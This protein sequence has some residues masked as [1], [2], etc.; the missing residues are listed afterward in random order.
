MGRVVH[1]EIHAEDPERAVAFYQAVFG[2]EISKWDGP[3]DYWLV[4]T[5]PDEEAGINGAILRQM[6]GAAEGGPN[7]F[8]CTVE[9]EDIAAAEKAIPDAGGE[10][11]VA[12]QEIPGVGKVSYF[13]DTEGNVFGALEPAAES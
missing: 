4:G 5:G 9:V 6:D 13:K 10:Q 11:V 12:R 7:A 1:F 3:V 2:W 8:V